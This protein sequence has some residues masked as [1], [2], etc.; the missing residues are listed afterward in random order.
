MGLTWETVIIVVE[1]PTRLPTC[2]LATPAMPSMG[3]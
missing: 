2:E 3:E 1:V